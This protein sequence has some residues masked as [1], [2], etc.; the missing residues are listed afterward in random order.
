MTLIYKPIGIILGILGGIVGRQIFNQIWQRVDK[1]EPPEPTTRDTSLK[2]VIAAVAL[3]GMIFS[4]V[5]MFIQRG[6]ARTWKL[7]PRRLAG[8]EAPRPVVARA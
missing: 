7:L 4:V 1:E 3:Q 5:K 6:G 2:R 8:R